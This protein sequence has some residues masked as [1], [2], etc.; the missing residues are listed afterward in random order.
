MVGERLYSLKQKKSGNE[1][2]S[3]RDGTNRRCSNK[4][5]CQYH[6]ERENF[7]MQLKVIQNYL[8]SDVYGV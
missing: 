8:V 3:I 2:D 1:D 7:D 4:L 6:E 5:C